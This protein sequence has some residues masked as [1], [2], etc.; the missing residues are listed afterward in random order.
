MQELPFRAHNTWLSD[1]QLFLLDVLF[2]GGTS[3]ELLRHEH[4]F[5]QWNLGYSHNLDDRHLGCEL[6]WLC[7]HGVLAEVSYRG[8]TVFQMTAAGGELW[9][10]ERCPV[11]DR[12]CMNRFKRTSKDRTLI[13]VIAVSPKVRDDFLTLWPMTS[14]RR[15][16]SKI[17]NYRLITWRPFSECFVG[18]M[19]YREQLEWT[20][21]EYA[22]WAEECLQ[23]QAVL[24]RE[25][26]WWRC[27]RELQRFV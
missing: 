3:F 16:A 19:I 12:Y 27:V 10:Q 13:S 1:E 26:S 23:H 8:K 6:Q 11:W 4:F 9:S 24:E 7:Q 15:R 21:E 2:D 20:C 18:V 5:E 25:R 22:A 17:A 14:A